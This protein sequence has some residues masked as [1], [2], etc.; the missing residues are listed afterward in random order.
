MQQPSPRAGQS[1]PAAR[2]GAGRLA[3]AYW[4]PVVLFVA[5]I[6]MVSSKPRLKPPVTFRYADKVLHMCEYGALGLLVSRA[7]RAT[8]PGS[9]FGTRAALA[10]AGGIAVGACDEWFQSFVPGRESSV[11]D[12]M[13]DAAGVT[14]A[15]WMPRRIVPE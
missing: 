9:P 8:A 15:Q 13:A 1:P 12:L 7:M 4:L 11:Y 6:F 10:I 14:L 2:S 3:L 5:L